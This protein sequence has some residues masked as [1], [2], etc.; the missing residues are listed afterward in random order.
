MIICVGGVL[1]E[2]QLQRI[3]S[4]LRNAQFENGERTAGWSA[5]LVKKNR[6][7]KAGT[8][9]HRAITQLSIEAIASND[10][11]QS[12]A[13]PR[14]MRPPLVSRYDTG[15][16]YGAH[17][18]DAFMGS[19]PERTDLSY[20]LFISGPAEYGG[21]ELIIDDAEGDRSY[22][23]EPGAL[24]L[25]PSTYLHR[26][27]TVTSGER[28]VIVG[29]LQSLCKDPRHREVLFDLARVRKTVFERDGKSA[30]FD[31]LSKSYSNLLRLFSS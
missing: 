5:K 18:D 7:M 23:L 22:K 3:R 4:H 31:L 17:V 29:W 16:S 28:V 2:E 20:T 26:V 12:A 19:P 9:Q 13:L 15:M 1:S 21:G 14:S 24:V 8:P 10:V 27:E 11:I 30:E 25:Y 6:Q